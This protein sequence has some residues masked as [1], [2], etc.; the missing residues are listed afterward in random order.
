M[1]YN[2]FQIIFTG[3]EEK[4]YPSGKKDGN[5]LG[6]RKR[7]MLI[8]K[9]SGFIDKDKLLVEKDTRKIYIDVAVKITSNPIK[10]KYCHFGKNRGTPWSE[11]SY[12]QLKY[13][14]ELG[15]EDICY[16]LKDLI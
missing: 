7:N 12:N 6:A 3:K 11:M 4:K 9:A 14:Y 8:R 1:F 16:T 15:D 5:K 2:G 10:Y 13:Y